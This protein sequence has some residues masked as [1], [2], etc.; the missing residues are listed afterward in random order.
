MEY[1]SF[2]GVYDTDWH[3]ALRNRF[4]PAQP[5]TI[6]GI[7]SGF[8]TV[9][10]YSMWESGKINRFWNCIIYYQSWKN[11]QNYG[12]KGFAAPEQYGEYELHTASDIYAIGAIFH[13]ILRSIPTKAARHSGILHKKPQEKSKQALQK[14]RG[15]T[16]GTDPCVKAEGESE[17]ASLKKHI[18]CGGR[19]RSRNHPY[20]HCT[21]FIFNAGGANALYREI[22]SEKR[23]KISNVV[24]QIGRSREAECEEDIVICRNFRGSESIGSG[25]DTLIFDY[26]AAV[27]EACMEEA[28]ITV[29]V[30]NLSLW[31]REASMKAW[32]TLRCVP[33]L[34]IICNHSSPM[35]AREF[36]AFIGREVYC[37]PRDTMPFDGGREKEAF[38]TQMLSK[39]GRR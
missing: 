25:E 30:V 2:P 10:H 28:E 33:N 34:K 4:I 24:E 14:R 31:K 35:E 22:Q 1:V 38:F 26:G 19:I 11:Y 12:T 9:T 15:I 32:Q 39:E 20:S 6:S 16:T 21:D 18:C 5:E 7:T 37:Y 17:R 8:K 23:E 27:E 3:A 13:F 29:L 36:A